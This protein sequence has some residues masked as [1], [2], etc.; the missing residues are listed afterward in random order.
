M[1]R[2]FKS[3]LC[4]GRMKVA[5]KPSH[6]PKS[7]GVYHIQTSGGNVKYV[8]VSN[9]LQ[10]RLQ[11]HIAGDKFKKNNTFVYGKAKP[12]ISAKTLGRTE[13]QHIA[14]HK[15]YLNKTKGGNG[16]IKT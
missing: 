11:Q 2:S 4:S 7:T 5:K 9:N 1:G 13:K 14:K 8:G 12:N 6:V 16:N 3:A 10:R 15:P